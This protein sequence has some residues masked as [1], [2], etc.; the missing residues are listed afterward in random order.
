MSR[1]YKGVIFDLDG[2]LLNTIEDIGDSMN[3]VLEEFNL[4][5][6]TYEEYKQKVGGGFKKLVLKC[7]PE[8]T[9]EDTIDKAIDMLYKNYDK[10]YLNKLKPYDGIEEILNFMVEKDIK[11]GVNSNKKDEYTKIIIEKFF[12]KILFVRVYGEREGITNK[13][14][15]TSALEIAQAMELK[16]EEILFIG[17][18]NAD[19]MTA[20]NANMDSV[21][22]LWGFR[23]REELF[24]Y[25]A[26]YIVSDWKEIIDIVE[27][28]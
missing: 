3:A 1:K 13:P 4:P 18:S 23:G 19:I 27:N 7:L 2:T 10:R 25:G 17:D 11:L 5:A 6:Y 9:D 14:D 12:G 26:N 24:K 20:K 8:G 21:G 28:S 15:P 22:V 16:P